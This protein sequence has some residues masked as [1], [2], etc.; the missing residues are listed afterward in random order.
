MDGKRLF[1]AKNR[2]GSDRQGRVL[3]CKVVSSNLKSGDSRNE[4]L[5]EVEL[6]CDCVL[7]DEA[8]VNRRKL[9]EAK[10]R[11]RKKENSKKVVDAPGQRDEAQDRYEV[12]QARSLIRKLLEAKSDK[13][14]R[15]GVSTRYTG[16]PVRASNSGSR[17]IPKWIDLVDGTFVYKFNVFNND[18]EL[19]DQSQLIS[20]VR[21]CEKD[22]EQTMALDYGARAEFDVYTKEDMK[23][24]ELFQGDRMGIFIGKYGNGAFHYVNSTEPANT[25]SFPVGQGS[26][27][28]YGVKLPNG[29][30]YDYVPY[31]IL[32]SDDVPKFIGGP[33]NI[34][35]ISESTLPKQAEQDVFHQII[36]TALSHEMKEI[37][38][39][40]TTMN[41][42]MFDHYAP[43]VKNWHWAEFN[44]PED[45]WRCTN[46]YTGIRENKGYREVPEFLKEFPTGGIIFAVK[47]IGDVV[48]A[49]FASLLNSYLVD[50]WLM[51][52]H[53]LATFWQPYN[54]DP[55]LKY[56]HLGYVSHPMEPYGGL[57]QLCFFISFDDAKTRLI[58]VQ[59][60]GPVTTEMRGAHPDNNFPPDYV[61]VRELSKIEP[62]MN[63][64]ALID[65][66]ENY[67]PREVDKI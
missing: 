23:R 6:E 54:D 16:R 35:A 24:S 8:S 65:M 47:E 60:K 2:S 18:P 44:D 62:G 58:E 26:L 4:G 64:K 9:E 48:S 37:I 7:E 1:V 34:Y 52:N 33:K 61:I 30:N 59:N 31:S 5:S 56:D 63:V 46:G 50:G 66:I 21:A 57:H 15:R 67:D 53:P 39:D 14:I 49:G 19:V 28:G 10:E 22:S 29:S 45:K 55:D 36:A 17:R 43:T 11:R 3:N 42:I 27:S 13:V 51:Q 38:G 25:Y 12:A 32:S 41:W 40:D 20:L